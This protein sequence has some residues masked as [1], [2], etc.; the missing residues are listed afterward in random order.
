MPFLL[1]CVLAMLMFM[2]V[3]QANNLEEVLEAAK[4]LPMMPVII[5][6]IFD[7]SR[8]KWRLGAFLK[9]IEEIK[10]ENPQAEIH[11]NSA[12]RFMKKIFQA[13]AILT[14]LMFGFYIFAQISIDHLIF[15]LY[16][17]AFIENKSAVYQFYQVLEI[18]VSFYGCVAYTAINE[19]RGSLLLVLFHIMQCLREMLRHLKPNISNHEM[20]KKELLKCIKL[21]LQIKQ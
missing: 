9:I 16:F 7:F 3:F 12:C 2:S 21:H 18:V 11:I 10:A 17:P 6:S 19:F 15:P 5:Y 4:I 1:L 14:I 13:I 20:S 8:K